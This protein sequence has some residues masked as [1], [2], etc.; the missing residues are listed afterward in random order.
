MNIRKAKIEDIERINQIY[1]QAVIEQFIADTTPWEI[2]KRVDWFNE[3][4]NFEYPVFVAEIEN[5]L[6]GFL[7]ISPYR[8]GR[9]AL[10]HTVEASFFID[11]NYRRMGIGKKLLEYAET[12]CKKAG[13]KIIVAIILDYNEASV[14]LVEKCGFGKWGHLP[15]I[16]LFDNT[17]VGH[18]Y[19]GKRINI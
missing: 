15:E 1:N 17:E 12:E 14:N 2:N 6:T 5:Y 4:N 3:H 18:F 9:M 8:Q 11:K 13:I 19:Y 10:K 7:Y 16:A